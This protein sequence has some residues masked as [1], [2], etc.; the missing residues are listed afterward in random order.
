MADLEKITS[1][2]SQD[3]D[4]GLNYG[5]YKPLSNLINQRGFKDVIEIGCAYGNLAEH[6]LLNCEIENL[7]SV[8]PYKAYPQMPGIS[9]QSDYD[10]LY[11]F[12]KNKLSKYDEHHLVRKTSK[13]F[14]GKV[15][16]IDIVFID[17]FHEYETVKWEIAHY[18]TIIRPN[19]I[20]SG[21]DYNVFA[22]VTMA[23]DEYR[24]KTGNS[25]FILP[26]NI[27]YFEM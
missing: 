27:W 20:L 8:D 2:S 13:S 7:W 17:G 16:S 1:I 9:T 5:H 23:V 12:T 14:Y 3:A 6:I 15:D 26:G 25:L 18:S 22:D 24:D 11:E 10:I 19:G 4:I 21:H